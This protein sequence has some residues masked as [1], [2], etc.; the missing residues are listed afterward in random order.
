MAGEEK[1]FPLQVKPGIKRDGTVFDSEF[2]TDGQWVRFQRG[3]AKKMGGFRRITDQMRGPVR[4]N[5]VWSRGDLNAVFGFSSS[6]IEQ[7]LIDSNGLGSSI[8]DR[9][10]A[11]FAPNANI[12]WSVDTQYDDAVGSTGTIIL[13]HAS[14]SLTNIDDQTTSK[15]YM[16]LAS[17]NNVFTTITDAPAVSGGVFAIPP[18]TVVHGSDGYVAWSDANQPQVWPGSAGNIGDA[19]ADRVAATKI[20]KGLP[21]RSGRGPAALL[22]TLDSVLRMD[23]VGGQAI[24]QFS[25]LSS[26]SSILAQNSIIEYDGVYFWIGTDR[27]MYFDSAVKELPNDMNQNYFFDNLNYEARQKVHAVKVPRFGE[28]W[29]FYP[30]GTNTECDKAVIF[31]V[32]EKVWYDVTLDRSAGFYSQVLHFPIWANNQ[33]TT[34]IALPNITNFNVG[35]SATGAASQATGVITA[36]D[37]TYNTITVSNVVGTFIKLE[38]VTSTGGGSQS[39]TF[40]DTYAS[41][42]L[43]QHEFLKDRIEG[44]FQIAIDSY[45]TTNDFGFANAGLNNWTRLKRVEP[46]F[47]QTGT[48]SVT[49]IGQEFANSPPDETTTYSFTDDTEYIDMREQH[50]HIRLKFE[51]NENMGDYEM[52]RVLLHVEPGDARS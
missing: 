25:T 41:A 14:S 9:T 45:I 13:A 27:F 46:D 39:N 10:P 34:V 36:T 43:F 23:W 51:S 20:V 42:S 28:I 52:G 16:A 1:L 6:K 4:K 7:L 11:G 49:V 32:R 2:F 29:W 12:M 35:D 44:D 33:N 40:V 21:L 31:N 47:K 17:N 38:T 24:F 22:W 8:I 48:M 3:R 18:Y 5:L 19:G 37:S 50:R 30:S 15:P 26:Q